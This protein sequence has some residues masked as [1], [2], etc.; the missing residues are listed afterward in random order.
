MFGY[1]ERSQN[2]NPCCFNDKLSITNIHISATV[3]ANR[4]YVICIDTETSRDVQ[5]QVLALIP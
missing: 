2:K 4:I 5:M 1:K 3:P